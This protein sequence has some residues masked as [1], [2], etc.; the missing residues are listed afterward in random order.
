MV[1][2]LG[3]WVVW[4]TG[5]RQ[6]LSKVPGTLGPS[7]SSDGRFSNGEGLAGFYGSGAWAGGRH[8]GMRSKQAVQ[9][10]YNGAAR[11]QASPLWPLP[12]HPSQQLT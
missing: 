12:S 10:P 1:C 4:T 11:A 3:A 5:P 8:G 2:V 9:E 7:P 6:T